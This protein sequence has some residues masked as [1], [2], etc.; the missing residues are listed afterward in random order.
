MLM[1]IAINSHGRKLRQFSDHF[2]GFCWV[3]R[4]RVRNGLE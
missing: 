4:L 3:P 2:L 1:M